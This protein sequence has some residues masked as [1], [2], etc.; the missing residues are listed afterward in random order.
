MTDPG[1]RRDTKA[2]GAAGLE[3]L[4]AGQPEQNQRR[5]ERGDRA[6][7]GAREL[8]VLHGHVEERAVRLHVL[9]ANALG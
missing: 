4:R 1:F 5:V 9:Q 8:G 7:N 3:N 2:G 6:C